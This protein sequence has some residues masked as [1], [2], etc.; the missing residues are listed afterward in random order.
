MPKHRGPI[1][2]HQTSTLASP[3][4]FSMENA[5]NSSNLGCCLTVI[6]PQPPQ[7]MV[8][9]GLELGDKRL[10]GHRAAGGGGDFFRI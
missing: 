10:L 7:R 8:D 2:E 5:K 9:L 1:L 6:T 3:S 4:D